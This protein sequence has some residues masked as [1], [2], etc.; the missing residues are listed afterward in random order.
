MCHERSS[1]LREQGPLTFST[2]WKLLRTARG[3]LDIKSF[4]IKWDENVVVNYLK[5][6]LRVWK[7]YFEKLVTP[8]EFHNFDE[9][10]FR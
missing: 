4:A 10:H 8:R 5:D 7:N 9:V 2:F 3:G 1:C 6:V